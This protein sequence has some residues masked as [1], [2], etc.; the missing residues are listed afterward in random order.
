METIRAILLESSNYL[1]MII[2]LNLKGITIPIS[3]ILPNFSQ[4]LNQSK[5]TIKENIKDGNYLESTSYGETQM[6]FA[7]L[8]KG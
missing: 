2:N 7:Y 1:F 6:N 5:V 3:C 8:S 4:S